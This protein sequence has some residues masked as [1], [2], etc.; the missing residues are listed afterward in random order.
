M[1]ESLYLPFEFLQTGSG[2]F[3]Q[4][5]TKGN[6]VEDA[7]SLTQYHGQALVCAQV[8]VQ[9]HTVP[10]FA[11]WAYCQYGGD[12]FVRDRPENVTVNLL[13]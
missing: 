13:Y 11:V 9:S 8:Y 6:I 12:F 10:I 4:P 1:F 3:W 5:E 7:E 2:A